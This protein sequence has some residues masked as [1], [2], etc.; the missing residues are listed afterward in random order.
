MVKTT[1][2]FDS[3]QDVESELEVPADNMQFSVQ[4]D[5]TT[6]YKFSISVRN[7]VGH[8]LQAS[9]LFIPKANPGKICHTV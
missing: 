5:C 8:S 2:P 9:E 4:M 3:S 7:E 6:D 1:P